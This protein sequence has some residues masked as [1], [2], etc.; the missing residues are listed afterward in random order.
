[1]RLPP[2]DAGRLPLIG[3]G[4]CPSA[5]PLAPAAYEFGGHDPRAQLPGP[6]DAKYPVHLLPSSIGYEIPVGSETEAA[7]AATQEGQ[8][9]PSGGRLQRSPHLPCTSPFKSTTHYAA[10]LL[11]PGFPGGFI[12]NMP[13]V[14]GFIYVK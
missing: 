8:A 12:R 7:I 14:V 11:Q 5:P 9:R 6:D 4:R 1:M 3:P 2:D 10:K 13:R